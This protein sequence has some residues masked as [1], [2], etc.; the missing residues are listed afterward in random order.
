MQFK[1]FEQLSSL[2]NNVREAERA[3]QKINGNDLNPE[4]GVKIEVDTCNYDMGNKI[5]RSVNL[6]G[7]LAVLV[8]RGVAEAIKTYHAEK[9][10]E[11]E[12]IKITE[13]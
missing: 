3:L 11:F 7:E 8:L 10:A 13:N 5:R 6:E 2:Y 9:L 4:R 1:Q 12:S